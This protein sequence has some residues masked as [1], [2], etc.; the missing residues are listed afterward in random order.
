MRIGTPL[1][2]NGRIPKAKQRLRSTVKV[3][4][5]CDRVCTTTV[6]GKL[7][8]VSGSGQ[9][10][11]VKLK[12][13]TVQVASDGTRTVKVKLGKAAKKAARAA[14]DSG[15]KVTV[16]LKGSAKDSA[17]NLSAKVKRGVTLT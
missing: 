3:K 11:S 1:D 6:S 16:K 4:A 5:G 7:K 14:L 9:K 12:S 17:G 15:G 13:V 2:S 8:A 10:V